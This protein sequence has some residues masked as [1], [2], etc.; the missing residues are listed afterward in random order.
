MRILSAD[1][2]VAMLD[3]GRFTAIYFECWSEEESSREGGIECGLVKGVGGLI[4]G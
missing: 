3:Q 2:L 4:D 1:K